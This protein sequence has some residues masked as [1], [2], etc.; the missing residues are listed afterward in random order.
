MD[1]NSNPYL[2]DFSEPM[3]Y[4]NLLAGI[5][6]SH[7]S[8]PALMNNNSNPYLPDFS[9][10]PSSNSSLYSVTPSPTLSL[11]S[12]PAS[13]VLELPQE[14]PRNPHDLP[15]F[16]KETL[17]NPGEP[18]LYLPPFLSTLPPRYAGFVSPTSMGRIPKATEAYLPDIDNASLSLHKALHNFTPI[19]EKYASTSYSEAFNWAE[20]DLPEEDE[21]E[22]YCVVFRSIRKPGS[23]NDPLYEADRAAHEEA[24]RNG[25]LIMYWYG[26]PD[27]ETGLNLATCLW[28]SRAHAIAANSRPDHIRAMR[29]AASSYERYELERWTLCKTAGSRRLEV[30]PYNEGTAVR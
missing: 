18:I 9:E 23:E 25:G 12:T 5:Y 30:L 14:V 28:Q 8:P 29:L 26:V 20:L 19:T 6:D 7:Q 16:D 21:H 22:W 2:P 11:V 10:P 17:I 3:A 24:V 1:T 15:V 13:D 4:K 27:A